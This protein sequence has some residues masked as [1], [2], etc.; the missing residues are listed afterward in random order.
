MHIAVGSHSR[1]PEQ[2]PGATDIGAALEDGERLD[3]LVRAAEGDGAAQ[4]VDEARG[5]G[6]LLPGVARAA[7]ALGGSLSL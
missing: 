1:I 2:V 6:E 7:A 5:A 3:D 4:G